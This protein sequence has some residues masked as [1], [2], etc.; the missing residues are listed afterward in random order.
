MHNH[1]VTVLQSEFKDD[2]LITSGVVARRTDVGLP[3]WAERHNSVCTQGEAGDSSAKFFLAVVMILAIVSIRLAYHQVIC[4][5]LSC[6]L[7]SIQ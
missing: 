7:E 5:H 4:L 1:H 3:F 6:C 2:L